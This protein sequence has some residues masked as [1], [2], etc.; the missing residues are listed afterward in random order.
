[1]YTHVV[2]LAEY[3]TCGLR[4]VAGYLVL[5]TQDQSKHLH[6][7]DVFAVSG[8]N[9]QVIISTLDSNVTYYFKVQA[10]NSQG[11]GPASNTLEYR[12][13]SANG[14]QLHQAGSH[15]HMLS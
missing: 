3:C 7:W 2:E 11:Y 15:S 8:T 13:H 12:T 9:T 4:C 1:M 10:R 6:D 5:Y 14:K